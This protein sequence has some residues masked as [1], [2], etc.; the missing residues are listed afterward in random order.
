MEIDCKSA[1][2]EMRTGLLRFPQGEEE[3]R[4]TA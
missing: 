4:E 1:E 3:N 2:E